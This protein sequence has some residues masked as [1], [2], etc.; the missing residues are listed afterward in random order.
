M[1]WLWLLLAFCFFVAAFCL[2]VAFIEPFLNWCLKGH[3]EA[4]EDFKR[5]W[6]S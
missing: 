6:N 4:A 3:N 2:A 1:I 5:G